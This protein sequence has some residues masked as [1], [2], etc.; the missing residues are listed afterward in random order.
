V[1]CSGFRLGGRTAPKRRTFESNLITGLARE[2][3]IEVRDY[4]TRHLGLK[5]KRGGFTPLG[6]QPPTKAGKQGRDGVCLVPVD[7]RLGHG[8]SRAGIVGSTW[9]VLGV[10][11]DPT[12]TFCGNF[13]CL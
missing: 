13:S 7:S 1:P 10:P 12:P 5:E 8:L 2:R 11:A 3:A 6:D 9:V 4:L